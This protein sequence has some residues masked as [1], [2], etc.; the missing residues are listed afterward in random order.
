[1]LDAQNNPVCSLALLSL[2]YPNLKATGIPARQAVWYGVHGTAYL[3]FRMRGVYFKGV[4]RFQG[5]EMSALPAST[6]N[7]VSVPLNEAAVHQLEIALNET[8]PPIIMQARAAWR[9][10]LPTLLKTH[11]GKWVAYHGDRQVGIRSCKT[12]LFQ[13][14]LRAGLDRGQFLVLRI[15]PEPEHQVSIPVDV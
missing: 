13:Q 6:P 3:R 12:D 15:E 1:M 9:R 14:C 11:P 7:P 8:F 2:T 10:D 4:A 5:V